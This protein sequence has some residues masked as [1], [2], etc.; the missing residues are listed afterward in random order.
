MKKKNQLYDLQGSRTH[1]LSSYSQ[2]ANIAQQPFEK[3]VELLTDHIAIILGES[4]KSITECSE[5][6]RDLINPAFITW[7]MAF[8][9]VSN[10]FDLRETD[11]LRRAF[12]RTRIEAKKGI[13]SIF[14]K[15]KRYYQ[16]HFPTLSDAELIELAEAMQEVLLQHTK[17]LLLKL[18]RVAMKE[19]AKTDP[20]AMKFAEVM[21]Q[22]KEKHVTWKDQEAA[23]REENAADVVPNKGLSN[24]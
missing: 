1:L 21:K 14:E 24:L 20:F 8:D 9:Q 10:E 5:L 17:D 16:N 15:D 7:Q 22:V 4:G 12:F 18:D 6:L 2:Y 19:R 3:G 23:R 13:R 11:T